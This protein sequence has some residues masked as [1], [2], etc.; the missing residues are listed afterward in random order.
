MRVAN[1]DWDDPSERLFISFASRFD[2]LYPTF[3][4]DVEME[5][6]VESGTSL[7]CPS[8]SCLQVVRYRDGTRMD[9]GAKDASI[10]NSTN[11]MPVRI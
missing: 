6:L 10:L 3:G 11:D 8:S 5:E 1:N 7:R 4:F 2:R 9:V